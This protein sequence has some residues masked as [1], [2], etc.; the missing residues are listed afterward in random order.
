MH[1]RHYTP[2]PHPIW[3]CG[4]GSGP[5]ASPEPADSREGVHRY[6][7]PGPAGRAGGGALVR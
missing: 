4:E 3:R 7:R 1:S 5:G 6:T 2:Y